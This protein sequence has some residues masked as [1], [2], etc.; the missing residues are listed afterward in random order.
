[1]PFLHQKNYSTVRICSAYIYFRLI[2]TKFSRIRRNGKVHPK[3]VRIAKEK[4]IQMP[5]ENAAAGDG[6]ARE[7]VGANARS[8]R[9]A[10]SLRRMLHPSCSF[11]SSSTRGLTDREL[12]GSGGFGGNSNGAVKEAEAATGRC[13]FRAMAV[14]CPA[15][16]SLVGEEDALRMRKYPRVKHLIW[17]DLIGGATTDIQ[18]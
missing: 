5:M 8:A 1:M 10:K 16:K 3:Q 15:S 12:L 6:R 18:L 4:C 7:Y 2:T 14:K 11:P 17:H 9:A 13:R